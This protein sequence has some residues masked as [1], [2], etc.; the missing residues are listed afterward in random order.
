MTAISR[1]AFPSLKR[2]RRGGKSQNQV[3][4]YRVAARQEPGGGHERDQ[5]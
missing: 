1:L 3:H 5:C 2:N 4:R